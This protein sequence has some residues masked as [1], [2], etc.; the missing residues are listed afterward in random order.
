MLHKQGK[1]KHNKKKEPKLICAIMFAQQYTKQGKLHIKQIDST[2]L[3]TSMK[4]NQQK[5]TPRVNL[6]TIFNKN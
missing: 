1:Q 5:E 6:C 2:S 3:S 4:D